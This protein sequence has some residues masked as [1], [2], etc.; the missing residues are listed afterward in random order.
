MQIRLQDVADLVCRYLNDA[1]DR[2]GL[3]RATLRLRRRILD[4]ELDV[5]DLSTGA[6]VSTLSFL[7]FILEPNEYGTLSDER[8]GEILE[9][10]VARLRIGEGALLRRFLPTLFREFGNLRF[11]AVENPLAESTDNWHHEFRD[12]WIDVGLLKR[13]SR[14]PR[15]FSSAQLTFIPLSVFTGEFFYAQLPELLDSGPTAEPETSTGKE[16]FG[17]PAGFCRDPFYYHPENDQAHFLLERY[18]RLG[19]SHFAFQY[20]VDEAGLAEIVLDTDRIG[21]AELEFSLRLFCLRNGVRRA[22]LDGRCVVDRP[23][24]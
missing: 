22:T 3:L 8:L 16:E 6:L 1:P 12:Q 23:D 19:T 20:F 10:I 5:E 17:L 21:P 24:G 11:V 9:R 14:A 4:G 7:E 18:P 13:Q 2:A 15:R